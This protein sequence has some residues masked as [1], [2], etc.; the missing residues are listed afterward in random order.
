MNLQITA[1]LGGTFDVVIKNSVGTT[2][3][4]ATHGNEVFDPAITTAGDYE[5]F[6]DGAETPVHCFTI[7]ACE[8]PPFLAAEIT[9][10]ND[11]FY[12]FN[13][14]FD[15]SGW[16][17]CPFSIYVESIGYFSA[18]YDINTLADFTLVT[19]DL[20]KKTTLIG[21]RTDIYYRVQ[22][23]DS[24][25][26]FCYDGYVT[27]EDCVSPTI[28]SITLRQEGTCETTRTFFI[29]VDF[30]G[31]TDPCLL[32]ANFTQT[33]P[34]SV[35]SDTATTT[36]TTDGTWSFQVFP[37]SVGVNQLVRFNVSVTDCCGLITTRTISLTTDCDGPTIPPTLSIVLVG[38]VYY[39]RAIYADCGGCCHG[40][41]FS[42]NQN[43]LLLSGSND[44]GVNNSNDI[45]CGGSFPLTIDYPLSP[46]L[47]ISPTQ[48]QIR[49]FVTFVNCC[50]EISPNNLVTI[51]RP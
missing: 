40:A 8:C 12:Y 36:I 48:A 5:M 18:T 4:S 6:I 7:T 46:N 32:N 41:N 50:N 21:G 15:I 45:P 28:D 33:A 2:V 10:P 11:V 29:D 19:S 30:S 44:T 51:N 23:L 13:I 9:T 47:N 38:S 39:L 42:Y 35:Y 17:F 37:T 24:E 20:A 25:A 16:E 31:V 1:P 43:N 14:N 22:L 3:Y 34:T 27:N 49:Y 26:T